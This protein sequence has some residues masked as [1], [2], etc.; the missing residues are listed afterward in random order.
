MIFASQNRVRKKK[1]KKKTFLGQHIEYKVLAQ[2]ERQSGKFFYL[3][4][5]ITMSLSMWRE[6]FRQVLLP[7]WDKQVFKSSYNFFFFSFS[8]PSRR[9]KNGEKHQLLSCQLYKALEK[10]L[11]DSFSSVVLLWVIKYA[12]AHL[13]LSRRR[14]FEMG[15]SFQLTTHSKSNI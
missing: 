13:V 3:P 15:R 10:N 14:S 12:N 2:R 8:S 9:R 11:T 4:P 6:F 1:K 5:T 7:M